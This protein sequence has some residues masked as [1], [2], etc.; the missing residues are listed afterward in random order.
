MGGAYT[1]EVAERKE[2]AVHGCRWHNTCQVAC[3]GCTRMLL[4]CCKH[5][6]A[7]AWQVARGG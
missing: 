1:E 6:A 2:V 5:A 4:A 3:R 7:K